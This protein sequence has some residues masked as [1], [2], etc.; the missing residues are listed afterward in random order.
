MSLNITSIVVLSSLLNDSNICSLCRC[1]L[2][3]IV[4]Q[5]GSHSWY[6]IS[7]CVPTSFI[8]NYVLL[9]S[10]ED[11]TDS[12]KPRMRVSSV[13][14]SRYLDTLPCQLLGCWKSQN[15]MTFSMTQ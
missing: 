7:L 14:S 10:V 4:V 6:F 12:S 1:I 15:V 5:V 2:L 3:F 11:S 13:V 8:F 9:L